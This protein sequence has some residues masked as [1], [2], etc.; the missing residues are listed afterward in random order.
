M[1]RE[2]SR[3]RSA[4]DKIDSAYYTDGVAPLVTDEQYEMIKNQL[5]A[6]CPDDV[7][8]TRVG[9]PYTRA[10]LRGKIKHNIVMGSLNNMDG[11]VGGFDKWY[12]TLSNGTNNPALILSHKLDGNSIELNYE[13]GVLKSVVTRGNG[14]Y[15]EDITA[16]A[17]LWRGVPTNIN[18][19]RKLS[20]RGEVLLYRDDFKIVNEKRGVAASDITNPRNVGSG[21]IGRSD[22]KFN[23]LMRFVAFNA[24][25]HD[26]KTMIDVFGLLDRLRFNVVPHTIITGAD[27]NNILAKIN[28][29][30]DMIFDE[31][32]DMS[33]SYINAVSDIRDDL[34]YDIDGVV[35]GLNNLALRDMLAKTDRDKMRPKHSIAVKF[36]SFKAST[37]LVDVALTV[38]HTG[39]ISPT[40]IVEP[41]R[42]GG[43]V[44]SNVLLNNWDL[45]SKY[46]S[47]G[48]LAI[49][50]TIE[51][52][53]AG[54]IIP[55]VV[56]VVV[57]ADDRR[58]MVEPEF[59]PNCGAPTTRLCRGKESAMTFCSNP[60]EC[61]A[62]K[63]Y[64]IRHYIGNA[65]KGVGILG[66]GDKVLDALT[67][68]L[69]K[70]PADLYRLTLDDLKDLRIGTSHSGTP[71]KMGVKN[72]TKLLAEIEKSKK[73]T[74]PKFLGAIGIDL[75][76][77][78]KVEILMK[79]CNL[80]TIDDWFDE[81]K[82][83]TIKGD[84]TR[85]SITDG[86]MKYKPLIRE[87]LDVGIEIMS[88]TQVS[89]VINENDMIKHDDLLNKPLSGLT[90]CWT[91]TRLYVKEF[92][93]L[94]GV[95]KSGI[96]KVL[97]LLV[98][99]DATSTSRKTEK[100]ES[101]GIKIIGVDY[102]KKIINGEVD[103]DSLRSKQL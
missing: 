69:V 67:D 4:I 94:G 26:C 84:V 42:I 89:D 57:P 44:V 23:S 100:A 7:R 47:A 56:R 63:R 8:F 66:I 6:I 52:E 13:D 16:N 58:V 62:A 99:K 54:D 91:G 51:I 35:V 98:Q 53:L 68:S 10:N 21:I 28:K 49:G 17:V 93:A 31:I 86:L 48:Q 30:L 1:D 3:L 59:C 55:H 82:L 12:G 101:Y 25:G 43:V 34:D 36:T 40:A 29:R 37:K 18:Y 33:K 102:M 50:D 80:N 96:S 79:E 85:K 64:K 60:D 78:R 90:A 9:V 75:L 20:V 70:S 22:G 97:D 38:G 32:V 95:V 65:K 103:V 81:S 24:V 71:I 76:G 46:P 61:Q 27:D 11:G 45:N 15:G 39:Q 87:L 5:K 92:E 83:A 41:V 72:A 2:I 73:L 77:R 74:L 88:D 14:E 19:S